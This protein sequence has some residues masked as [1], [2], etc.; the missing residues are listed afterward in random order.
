MA[1]CLPRALVSKFQAAVDSGF[2]NPKE[3][4]KIS[5]EDR[6]NRIASVVGE[7]NASQVN[8]TFEKGILLERRQL[9]FNNWVR[10]MRGEMK[11][12]EA[13]KKRALE[14]VVDKI[15]NLDDRILNPHFEKN[16]MADL[17]AEQLGAKVSFEDAKGIFELAQKAKD[18]KTEWQKDL[19][20]KVKYRDYNSPLYKVRIDY[21]DALKALQDKIDT[22]K[23]NGKSFIENALNTLLVPKTAETGIFHLSA[24]GVQSWGSLGR[25]ATYQALAHQFRYLWD[26]KHYD[27][28]MSYIVSHPDYKTLKDAGLGLV[29]VSDQL[30][31]RE[32]AIQSSLLQQLNT[33]VAEQGGKA[34]NLD[35]PL[36][37]NI[38]GASSR[39]F[40]GFLN[41]QRFTIATQ[42][43][44]K[45]R[46]AQ[47]EGF[48]NQ[49]LDRGT[50]EG[51][52]SLDQQ[53]ISDI[54]STVNNFSGRGNLGPAEGAH[55][56]QQLLN[57][58]FFAPRKVVATAQMFNPWEYGRLYGE[59]SKTGNYT[60]ANAAVQNLM[61]SVVITGA[62]LGAAKVFGYQVNLDATSQDFLKIVHGEEKYDITGGSAIWLR[63]LGRLYAN[64]EITARNK[65]IELGGSGYK[66]LT[67]ADLITKYISGK[68]S[69]AASI[70]SDALMGEDPVGN[71]FSMTREF[72][73]KMQPIVMGSLISYWRQNPDKSMY[74]LPVLASILGIQAESPTPPL[75][76]KGMSVW[77]EPDPVWTDPVRT[78]F[79][80]K[81]DATG[82]IPNFPGDTIKGVKLT[83]Q[84]YR[85]YIQMSGTFA[86]ARLQ[87]LLDSPSFGNAKPEIQRLEIKQFIQGARNQAQGTL[88]KL[89]KGTSNDIIDKMTRDIKDKYGIADTDSSIEKDVKSYPK[90]SGG[91][92]DLSKPVASEQELKDQWA[93]LQVSDYDY[94]ALKASNPLAFLGYL[95][96]KDQ[97]VASEFKTPTSALGI[98]F[99]DK[100]DKSAEDYP[101]T[102]QLLKEA[103]VDPDSAK[104]HILLG[105]E[106]AEGKNTYT[107]E[108]ELMHRGIMELIKSGTTPSVS[109]HTLI[110]ANQHLHGSD[111]HSTE[112]ESDP[113][114]DRAPKGEKDKAAW[115]KDIAG[116]WADDIDKVQEVAKQLVAK[117]GF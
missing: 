13:Q 16:F 37:I 71:D 34:L 40:T 4:G 11:G 28:L 106:F 93:K 88:E 66:P 99:A 86:K 100:L 38:V 92:P 10:Q 47:G 72:R 82:Y 39:A 77:G 31:N 80:N 107:L 81:L 33:Y 41:Y 67:R 27:E 103:G 45:A 48:F 104:G 6:F 105:P 78:D 68:F 79:D 51:K 56:M 9:G 44:D 110:S 29:D 55:K 59:A 64:R 85:Q 1:Y 69:P 12:Q 91:N 112:L 102:K 36:P 24:F 20:T 35:Q 111:K 14:N 19:A 61:S 108:H 73:D 89:S 57:A 65:E 8:A 60:A 42:L 50:A 101:L 96:V 23:P 26:Q 97:G 30:S 115:A 116:A 117:K 54:A 17:A 87:N 62:V 5:S 90:V 83:D 63:L 21:G 114:L 52:E 7:D 49:L 98:T 75:I 74:D 22:S 25:A 46:R 43:L 84:Q 113:L 15:N 70:F 94:G 32:E 3:L 2:L 109:D 76:R 58:L 18:A 53:T 95:A